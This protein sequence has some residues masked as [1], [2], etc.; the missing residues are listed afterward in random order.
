MSGFLKMKVGHS[1]WIKRYVVLA[2]LSI[3][4]FHR[5]SQFKHKSQPMDA[6]AL[7]RCT[8]EEN[9]YLNQFSITKQQSNDSHT[10]FTFHS[11]KRKICRRWLKQ[12]KLVIAECKLVE[13]RPMDC[14]HS[15]AFGLYTNSLQFF[16]ALQSRAIIVADHDSDIDKETGS[17]S[18]VSNPDVCNYLIISLVITH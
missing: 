6:I 9:P 3:A 13:S 5:K 2:G 11:D 10:T 12:L 16:I 1:D 14:N 7:T 4:W 17:I 8:M 18:S 15:Q